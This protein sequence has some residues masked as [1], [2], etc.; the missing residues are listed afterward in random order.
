MLRVGEP[1]VIPRGRTVPGLETHV[2]CRGIADKHVLKLHAR[3][4]RHVGDL[5][6]VAYASLSEPAQVMVP[7]DLC[8]LGRLQPSAHTPRRT[9]AIIVPTY[10][11]VLPPLVQH[12]LQ[13]LI[14]VWI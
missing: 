4:V 8:R 5:D 1:G 6:K 13:R 3:L 11:Q 9:L 2:F 12:L 7:Q 14:H 10:L